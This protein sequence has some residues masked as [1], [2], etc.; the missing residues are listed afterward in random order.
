MADRFLNDARSFNGVSS[1]D[2]VAGGFAIVRFACEQSHLAGQ[3]LAQ[4]VSLCSAWPCPELHYSDMANLAGDVRFCVKSRH[5]FYSICYWPLL[6]QRGH[7]A[8]RKVYLVSA[9]PDG[10]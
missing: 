6:A 7:S 10:I 1:D 2:A 5:R 4:S 9:S 3:V 8:I